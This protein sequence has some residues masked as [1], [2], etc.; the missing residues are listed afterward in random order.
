[1]KGPFTN[2]QNSKPGID[3]VVQYEV[4]KVA[5]FFIVFR[6][7]QRPSTRSLNLIIFR[8]KENAIEL[9]NMIFVNT[10]PKGSF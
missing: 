2:T 6:V 7:G 5:G 4:A 9:F 1:M 10:S 3:C 8:T